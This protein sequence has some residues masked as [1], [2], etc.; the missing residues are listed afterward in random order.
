MDFF[1]R[2]HEWLAAR[3][4]WVQYPKPRVR[5]HN[6][7]ATGWKL[8]WQM[9]KPMNRLFALF[10]PTMMLFVPYVGVYLAILSVIFLFAYFNR[11]W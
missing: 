3:I 9:R 7:Y 4:S 5:N 8:R 10:L 11:R 1:Y 6:G 2:T